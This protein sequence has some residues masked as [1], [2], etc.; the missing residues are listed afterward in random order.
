MQL[1][2]EL[3]AVH[4]DV[5]HRFYGD[6]QPKENWELG[7]LVYLTSEQALADLA[8]FID[9]LKSQSEKESKVVVVGGS[10]PGAM[11]A[12][13]KEFYPHHADAAWSSSGVIN[14]FQDYFYYDY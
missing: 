3:G 1:A 12:W 5:E 4:V 14:P 7:N 9:M 10:Y 13:F 6:S 2:K 8:N 11:V